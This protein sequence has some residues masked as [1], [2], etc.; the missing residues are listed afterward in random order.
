MLRGRHG[1]GRAIVGWLCVLAAAIL[2]L[3]ALAEFIPMLTGM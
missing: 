2:M 3:A 1:I